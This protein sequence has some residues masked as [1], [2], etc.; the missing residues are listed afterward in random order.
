MEHELPFPSFLERSR[1][2]RLSS[3]PL[4]LGLLILLAVPVAAQGSPGGLAALEEAKALIYSQSGNEEEV[5]AL[6]ESA[7][8][9]IEEIESPSRRA[10]NLGRLYLLRGTFFNIR[11]E[12]RRAAEALKEAIRYAEEAL[13][14]E[15]FSEGYRLLADAHSQM[16]MARGIFYMARHGETARAAALRSLELD[17]SNS[18]AHISVA[19]YYL[20]APSIAGGDPEK[21]IEILQRGVSLESAGRS[22]RFLMYL[23]LAETHQELGK[24]GEA[25]EYLLQARRIFPQS[26]Q[27]S[28][29]F[30]RIGSE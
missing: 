20:N 17:K 14:Q 21:G 30:G 5:E 10:Y 16:M 3:Y 24:I 15:E 23:W 12:S 6:L 22:E 25:R 13:E 11:E 2:F 8:S 27:V 28:E 4:F 9:T 7:N 18:R 19:G 1:I 29:L 26:P